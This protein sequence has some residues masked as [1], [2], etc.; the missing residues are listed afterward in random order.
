[1]WSIG[2]AIYVLGMFPLLYVY[3]QG[4]AGIGLI[5]YVAIFGA[6]VV[7]FGQAFV[8]FLPEKKDTKLQKK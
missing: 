3:Q 8:A 5:D 6:F 1:M 7:M 4:D 2:A